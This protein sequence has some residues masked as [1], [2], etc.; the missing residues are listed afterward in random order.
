M[1]KVV[2][3]GDFKKTDAFLEKALNVVKLG[4]LDQYG[5]LGVAALEEAT[6]KDTG[7]TARS[8]YYKIERK[9]G[10]VSL[11]WCNSNNDVGYN[12]AVVLQYGHRT[13]RGYWHEG[14]DYINPALKP[15]FD[16]IAEDLWKEVTSK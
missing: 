13:N 8:W 14:I 2:Q 16:K 1:I 15:V 9:A 10:K 12:I 4:S 7:K 5:K 11:V 3:K 6:P